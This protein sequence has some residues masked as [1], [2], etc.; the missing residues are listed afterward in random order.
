VRIYGSEMDSVYVTAISK[1]GGGE[2]P[3]ADRDV[4]GHAYKFTAGRNT[5]EL[6]FQLGTVP[7]AGRNGTT[8]ECVLAAVVH[9]LKFLNGKFPCREN[10]LAITKLE[11]ALMWLEARTKNRI[12][13]G[14][15]GKH[16]V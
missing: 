5:Q 9:R 13:R 11:E 8:N 2:G 14:V 3:A 6:W 16:E 7:E 1:V 10:A 4:E 15:E 12:E